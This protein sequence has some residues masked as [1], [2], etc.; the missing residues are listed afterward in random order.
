LK[1]DSDLPQTKVINFTTGNP[2][3]T[4]AIVAMHSEC[5][6]M[7]C[8]FFCTCACF[9]LLS[10]ILRTPVLCLMP[11]HKKLVF[12]HSSISCMVSLYVCIVSSLSLTGNDTQRLSRSCVLSF[13]HVPCLWLMG[14]LVGCS[15]HQ[16]R[17]PSSWMHA[18]DL[19]RALRYLCMWGA[20]CSNC[21]ELIVL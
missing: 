20:L 3:T 16:N 6:I 9:L 7:L 13:V 18:G 5:V 8:S 4:V 15:L 14:L 11:T 10:A 21:S 2:E 19:K 1:I 12:L 17:H